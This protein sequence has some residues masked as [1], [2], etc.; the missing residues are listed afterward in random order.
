MLLHHRGSAYVS[1]QSPTL[2][3]KI[4]THV[5]KSLSDEVK[6][7]YIQSYTTYFHPSLPILHLP[8]LSS[9]STPPILLK[10]VVA[11]GCMYSANR[12]QPLDVLDGMSSG[13]L[14]QELWRTGCFE[15]ET[16]VSL[17]CFFS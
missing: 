15:L 14:S 7:N 10:A 1:E 5:R 12:A 17:A 4:L 16:F 9:N 6:Y 13:N 11:I 3:G 8:T 2:E